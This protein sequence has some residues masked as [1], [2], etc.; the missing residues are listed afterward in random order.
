MTEGDRLTACDGWRV[1]LAQ[2]TSVPQG[3]ARGCDPK[4]KNIYTIKKR[5]HGMSLWSMWPH[6]TDDQRIRMWHL[7]KSKSNIFR[8]LQHGKFGCSAPQTS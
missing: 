4:D 2:T 8:S 1:V 7:L 6:M 5:T 3:Y